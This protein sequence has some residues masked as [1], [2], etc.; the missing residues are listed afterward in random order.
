MLVQLENSLVQRCEIFMRQ[1]RKAAF[2]FSLWLREVTYCEFFRRRHN[3][4]HSIGRPAN[5]NTEVG[6]C[7]GAAWLQLSTS[8]RKPENKEQPAKSVAYI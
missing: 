3:I 4:G 5:C 6:A 7:N 8:N 2:L 1:A